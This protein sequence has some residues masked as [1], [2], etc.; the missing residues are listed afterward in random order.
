[1][2]DLLDRIFHEAEVLQ[3]YEAAFPDA[4]KPANVEEIIKVANATQPA[5]EALVTGFLERVEL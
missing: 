3:R 4:L 1:M 5:L 2:H